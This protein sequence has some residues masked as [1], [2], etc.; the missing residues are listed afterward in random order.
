MAA[1]GR[2]SKYKAEYAEQAYKFCL[3][4][5]DDNRLAAF[6]EVDP[7]TIHRW[8]HDH[9]QFCDSIKRGKDIA[10]AEIAQAL[11]H[12]A[13]G[14]SHKAVKMFNNQG[15]ILIEEYT[16][17]YPPDTGAAMAW[18]K[19]RQPKD[20]RDKQEIEHSGTLDVDIER[21]NDAEI[22]AGIETAI[23]AI[24]NLKK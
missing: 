2:P 11:Y 9:A 1:V 8:K 14:Y 5:A 13:K 12:R 4:G 17:H 20:W 21:M 23:Q 15:E 7:A 6:F 22:L 24:N 16:E 10:D 19:N 3:L 18:L